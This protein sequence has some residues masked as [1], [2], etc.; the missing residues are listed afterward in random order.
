MSMPPRRSVCTRSA[1]RMPRNASGSW[2]NCS[3]GL[4]CIADYLLRD[5]QIMNCSL[6]ALRGAL[7]EPFDASLRVGLQNAGNALHVQP[8][9]LALRIGIAFVGAD[10]QIRQC[11]VEFSGCQVCMRAVGPHP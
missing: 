3:L 11:L 7:L 5:L 10:R 9:E 2:T 1:S 6:V 4:S 8:A